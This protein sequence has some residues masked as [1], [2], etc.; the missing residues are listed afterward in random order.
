MERRTINPWRW[1]ETLGYA[2]AIEVTAGQRVL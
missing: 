1:Q 2:Q